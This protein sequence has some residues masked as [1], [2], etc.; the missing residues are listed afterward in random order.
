MVIRLWRGTHT[1]RIA[2]NMLW[3]ALLLWPWHPWPRE[4]ISGFFGR[5]SYA[6]NP[7]AQRIARFIDWLHPHEPNH[8]Y[9]TATME[10]N[11]RIAL[12]YHT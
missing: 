4:T 7:L 5:H 11:A 9:V 2:F 1:Q 6:G 3:C 10:H 8:C 12:E